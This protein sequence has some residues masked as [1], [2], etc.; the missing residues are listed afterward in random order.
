MVA[1]V[2]VEERL[3]GLGACLAELNS[4]IVAEKGLGR[5]ARRRRRLALVEANLAHVKGSSGRRASGRRGCGCVGDGTS[6]RLELRRRRHLDNVV[7]A[8]EAR[9]ASNLSSSHGEVFHS[10]AGEAVFERGWC[11]VQGLDRS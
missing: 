8:V 5:R 2:A 3:A 11:C 6:A 9:V 4:K 1:N 10:Q 7:K